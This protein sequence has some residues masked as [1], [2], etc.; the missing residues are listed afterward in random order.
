L[1]LDASLALAVGWQ[2]SAVLGAIA[3]DWAS[4]NVERIA[5]TGFDRLADEHLSLSASVQLRGV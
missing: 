3:S 4:R 1:A 2:L 5:A